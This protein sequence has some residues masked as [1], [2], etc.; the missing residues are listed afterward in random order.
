M[1]LAST[2]DVIA[3]LKKLADEHVPVSALISSTNGNRARVTGLLKGFTTAIELV[4]ATK[5]ESAYI[6]VPFNNR[7]FT[8]DFGDLRE[9]PADALPLAVKWGNSHCSVNFADNGD[10]LYVTFDLPS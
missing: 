10:F 7:P 1:N 4:L 6:A 8:F 9:V 2:D 5:D 3:L